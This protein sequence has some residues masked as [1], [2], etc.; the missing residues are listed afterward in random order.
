MRVFK[1]MA[2]SRFARK[3]RLEDLALCNSIWEAERGL[4]AANLGGGVIKQRI[5][6][7]GQGKSGGL[8]TIIVFRLRERAVFVYGFAKN[9]RDNIG[10]DELIALKKL[11]SELLAYDAAAIQSAIASGALLE[12]HCD[13]KAIS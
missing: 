12:V 13:A 11:A 6:R 4:I 7:S 2:F 3:A 5:G 8:R 9:E 10:E 1:N